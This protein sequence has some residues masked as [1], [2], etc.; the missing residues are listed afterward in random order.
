MVSECGKRTA[1]GVIKEHKSE[2][3]EAQISSTTPARC[4]REEDDPLRCGRVVRPQKKKRKEERKLRVEETAWTRARMLRRRAE[5]NIYERGWVL[6]A[7]LS[8][9]A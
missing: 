3:D 4:T 6:R 1:G 8:R 5:G 2:G 7:G 9:G